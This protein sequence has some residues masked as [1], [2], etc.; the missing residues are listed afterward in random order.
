VRRV[1]VLGSRELDDHLH[2][3]CFF[4]TGLLSRVDAL[5]ADDLASESGSEVALVVRIGDLGVLL[6][7]SVSLM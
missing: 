5:E 3:G 7:V 2:L 6:L 4:L 1:I